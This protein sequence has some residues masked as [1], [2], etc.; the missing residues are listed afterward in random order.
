M[1]PGQQFKQLP[2]F[3]TARDI[4]ETHEPN[5]RKP[6]EVSPS[7]IW[8]RKLRESKDTKDTGGIPIKG[9]NGAYEQ[10]SLHEHIARTGVSQAVSIQD[11]QGAAGQKPLVFDGHHRVASAADSRPNDL[12]PVVHSPNAGDAFQHRSQQQKAATK[13]KRSVRVQ[14]AVSGTD[15]MTQVQAH[16]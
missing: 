10:V 7:R 13:A 1:E 16:L 2:M 6:G 15:F 4:K 14:R 11:P 12:I 8:N 5:D 9:A 3:M